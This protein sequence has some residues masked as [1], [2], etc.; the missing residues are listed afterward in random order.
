M[1]NPAIVALSEPW[2]GTPY[3]HQGS[4]RQVACDCLGLI[5][6][7]WRERH[8]C[9]PQLIPPYSLD[10]AESGEGELLL[11]AA[12][13]YLVPIDLDQAGPGDVLLFRMSPQAAIK[14][15]AILVEG[16]AK[17]GTARIIHA[18][19]GQSVVRS[20]LGVWWRQRLAAAFAFPKQD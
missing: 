11:E 17:A 10:W 16:Q 5:S 19:W 15:C 14:H 13:R 18:Y 8:G 6:G 4:L 7:I 20:W 9:E 1:S 3:R 2:L 12:R